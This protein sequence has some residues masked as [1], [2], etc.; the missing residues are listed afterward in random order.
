M[1][2]FKNSIQ[3]TLTG[4]LATL[5][6]GQ[7]LAGD[8]AV[9]PMMIDIQG[10]ERSS[11]S[12]SF[13]IFGKSDSD[14]KLSLF[15]MNQLPSGYMGFEEADISNTESMANWIRLDNNAFSIRDGEVTE[16][17]GQIAVPSRAAGTYLVGVMVEEDI[18]EEDQVG[19]AVKIR[20]AVVLNM[21]VA[22]SANRRIKTSF[23]ELAVVQQEDGTYLEGMFSNDSRVDEWLE[24][25]VQIRNEDN[26]LI[27]RVEMRT[28]SAWQRNDETS[29]VFP[30]AQ[31]RVFGR[32]T[33]DIEPGDYKVMVRNRFADK[34]QPVYRDTVRFKE[35]TEGEDETII[36]AD[37]DADADIAS[38]EEEGGSVIEVS[39]A[40]LP[41][42]IRSNGTSFS[43]FIITN[44]GK[45][46]ID[47]EMPDRMDGIEEKG[48]SDFKFFPDS[49]QIKPGEKTRVVLQ[50]THVDGSAYGD[51]VFEALVNAENL[52]A[53]QKKLN[54]VTVGGS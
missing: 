19:V 34:S 47:V 22:G 16:V 13:S 40:A 50:Q 3:R 54:I 28:E 21:R 7:V 30:G 5:I 27:E 26:R 32:L 36:D 49:L 37:A 9:S 35:R 41:V 6:C 15:D 45:Q 12:F 42:E 44:N 2:S 52:S 1:K 53:D 11:H 23:E 20:Y 38:N 24:S 25:Q 33:E 10:V 29:R 39:P 17:S 8:F 46:Q 18:P 48:V 51:I 31:V 43:S 14:I 4:I